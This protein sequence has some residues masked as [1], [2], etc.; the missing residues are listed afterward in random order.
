MFQR[1]ISEEAGVARGHTL[2]YAPSRDNTGA[3]PT[4]V[5]RRGGGSEEAGVGGNS[6][7]WHTA[8]QNAF[9]WRGS[10]SCAR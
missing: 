8:G 9:R 10:R 5:G 3:R 2:G 4:A 7:V 6:V 1:W